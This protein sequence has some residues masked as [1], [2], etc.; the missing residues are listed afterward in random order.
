MT[1]KTSMRK[2]IFD[3]ECRVDFG[4]E[5][6]DIIGDLQNSKI[7]VGL[8]TTAVFAA[9]EESIKDWPYRSGSSSILSYM[10]KRLYGSNSK[11]LFSDEE[12]AL[13]YLEL[14]INLLHWVPKHYDMMADPY[15]LHIGGLPISASLD[16]FIEDISFILEQCNMR[17]RE[18][19]S[20]VFPKYVITKRDA[21]V[22]ATIDVAPELSEVL[23]SYLDIRNAKDEEFKKSAIKI[24]ADYLEPKRHSFDGT[25]YK[26]LC[27]DVF[28]AF[29]GISVRHNNAKQVSLKKADRMKL[30]DALFRMSLHLIQKERMD[31]YRG[32]IKEIK[33]GCS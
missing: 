17:V 20:P 10:K 32:F 29:N 30:Y 23:L 1:K 3:L 16:R 21:D 8:R 2:S 12:I 18:V 24:I 7:S 33:N 11:Q 5:F 4:E 15:D 22:D 25:G 14:Y 13:Y 31:E 9:L 19:Q 26:G 6:K 27:D 28:Y